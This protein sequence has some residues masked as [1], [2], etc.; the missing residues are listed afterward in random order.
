MSMFEDDEAAR[1]YVVIV[2]FDKEA[3]LRGRLMESAGPFV[4]SLKELGPTQQIAMSYDG[5]M[6]AYLVM[7]KGDKRFVFARLEAPASRKG[8]GLRIHD[9]IAIFDIADGFVPYF[10]RC[11]DWLNVNANPLRRLG[12]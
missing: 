8:S 4:T 2:K 12:K 9:C 11:E 3:D 10:S 5:S 7:A 6:C 1:P